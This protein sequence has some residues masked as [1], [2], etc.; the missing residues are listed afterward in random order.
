MADPLSKKPHDSHRKHPHSFLSFWRHGFKK[1]FKKS[2]EKYGHALIGFGLFY[3]VIAVF[4]PKKYA[5]IEF[6]GVDMSTWI[7]LIIPSALL[8]L[9]LIYHIARAPYE[10]YKEQFEKHEAEIGEKESII[11]KLEA[12]IESLCAPSLEIEGVTSDI[13]AA[14]WHPCQIRIHNKSSTKTA[15]NVRVELIS[16]DDELKMEAQAAYFRPPFP[17]ILNPEA[18]GMNTINP[19][20]KLQFRIFC[21]SANS[22]TAIIRDGNIV[23]YEQKLTARFNPEGTTEN[24]TAMFHC[25]KSYRLKLAV[26][27]RD[28]PNTDREFDLTFSTETGI[29]QIFLKPH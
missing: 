25:Q 16:L 6:L 26:T 11:K 20:G 3:T 29:C 24:N 27:A 5:T 2:W 15:D 13:K 17:V 7:Q 28:F 9:F 12:E 14:K 4:L 22:K 21:V 19:G 1:A 18:A 8:I 10:I 23:G